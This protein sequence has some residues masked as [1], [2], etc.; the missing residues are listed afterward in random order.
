MRQDDGGE[1]TS[2]DLNMREVEMDR[3]GAGSKN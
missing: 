3:P 1:R 2:P